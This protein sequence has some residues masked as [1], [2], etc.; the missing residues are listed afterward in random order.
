ME[1]SSFRNCVGVIILLDDVVVVV[2]VIV[3]DDEEEDVLSSSPS[4]WDVVLVFWEVDDNRLT[5]SVALDF[6]DGTLLFSTQTF[7]SPKL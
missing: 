3:V 2:V 6:G 5:M 4:S 1:D 7:F